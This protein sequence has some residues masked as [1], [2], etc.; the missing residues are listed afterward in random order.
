MG[1]VSVGR[2][3]IDKSAIRLI[4]RC[5]YRII[6]SMAVPA[7]NRSSRCVRRGREKP[8]T[9]PWNKLEIVLTRGVRWNGGLRRSNDQGT[10]REWS[11]IAFEYGCANDRL[12]GLSVDQMIDIVGVVHRDWLAREWSSFYPDDRGTTRQLPWKR[13]F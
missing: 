9:R 11:Q 7:R 4:D 6:G 3:V 8:T 5:A 10:G 13:Q 2:R 12:I 1:S